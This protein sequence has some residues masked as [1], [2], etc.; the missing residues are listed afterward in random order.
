MSITTTIKSIQDIMRKDA[1]V[2]WDAQ[3]IGQL[4]WMIFLKIVSDKEQELELLNDNYSYAIPKDLRWENWAWNDEW[5]TW[6]KMLDFV[7][8]TLFP[9]LKNLEYDNVKSLSFIIKE[10][11]NDSYNYM[12]NWTLIRQ[13]INKINEINFNDKEDK[14][15]FND[16]YENILKELQSAWNSWEFYTPRAVTQFVVDMVDPKLWEKILDPSCW[17]WWFLTCSIDNLRKK[18]K[19][20]DDLEI[21]QNSIYWNEV[22]QLP[23]LLATTN[24]ILHE[25]NPY[26]LKH[27]DSLARQVIDI[28]EKDRV[29]V[30]VTNPPFWWTTIDW[31]ETNFPKKFQ[32][33]ETADLFMVL[34]M[35][36]LKNWW[37]AWVVLP[38]WFLFWEWVKTNIKEK[39][40]SEFNLH[41]IVRLPNW[42]FS[43][44]T[45]ITTNLLFFE[46]WTPTKEIWYF[47]HPYPEWVKNYNKTAPIK[48]KEFDL[49]KSWWNKR[50]INEYAWKISIDDVI[51]NNYNLD[52]KNPNKK[53]SE[54]A[55]SKNE[56]IE[57]IEKNL[58]RSKEILELIKSNW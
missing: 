12:K 39:L 57:K 40:L 16:I 35:Y 23:H 52:F 53:Q 36:L 56:I 21:L 26:N 28:S 55:L 38:D 37:R 11:F 54:T 34:M 33:K 8:N 47:E 7:N 27:K 20:N 25:I 14:H 22:K 1:W 6:D 24:L 9:A 10:V 32:T 4:W 42:V 41:T 49:E 18:C 45:W 44:Y 3:R 31:T 58:E 17:T 13:V 50:E 46:K 43:P 48:I 51:K 30:I 29:D 15:I 2:D 19:T 5:I